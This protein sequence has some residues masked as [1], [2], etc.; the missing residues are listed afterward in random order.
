MQIAKI[1]VVYDPT[2]DVQPALGRA[3][4]IAERDKLTVH[5]FSCIYTDLG[6][7]G[8]ASAERK[9]LL[10]AQQEIVAAAAAPLIEKGI[11]VCHITT[12]PAQLP[13]A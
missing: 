7:S 5:L 6:K 4:V 11:D 3:S 13:G 12:A 8:D 10:R 9:K 1:L 2:T